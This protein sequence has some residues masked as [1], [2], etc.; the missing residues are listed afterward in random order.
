MSGMSKT[1][2]SHADP[3]F[4]SP[5]HEATDFKRLP[6]RSADGGMATPYP[7]DQTTNPPSALKL[8]GAVSHEMRNPLNGILGMSHLLGE[9]QLDG[10]QRNYLDAI[11]SSG[12]VLLTLVNDLLDLTALQSD[13]VPLSPTPTDVVQLVNQCLELAAPRAHGKGLSLGSVIDPVLSAA[14]S[15]IDAHEEAILLTLDGGRVRQVLT[16]LLS[17]AIKFTETGGVKLEVRVVVTGDTPKLVFDVRDTGHGIAEIDQALV[18]QTFGRTKSAVVAG[19]EGTGLGLPLSRGLAQAMGG[20]LRLMSSVTGKGTHMRLTLPLDATEVPLP[21]MDKPL[22]DQQVMLVLGPRL[23]S[24]PETDALRSTL[25]ALGATVHLVADNDAL[26][27]VPE[28]MDH[29]LIDASFDHAML[30]ARLCVPQAGIRPIILLKPD[31]RHMLA[32]LRDAG[33]CGYLIRPVRQSSLLAMLTHRFSS[34]AERPFLADPADQMSLTADDA[35]PAR[36]VLL[37]DDNQINAMLAKTALERAGHD[38]TVVGDGARAIATAA[39]CKKKGVAFD[40]ILLD[41]S[42]PVMDGFAAA[43]Q[44]RSAGFD[45]RLI[46]F[47]GNTDADLPNQIARAGFDAFA[48]KPLA[49]SA[50]QALIA[51]A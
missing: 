24:S 39:E 32:D 33:F 25:Q 37:A 12:E 48:Q 42:M 38:V 16:N 22:H 44:L 14:D 26:N 35:V 7:S 29:V 40:T 51:E 15:S 46:A 17:N 18:F 3:S 45:G 10:A 5:G 28:S 13:A 6:L 47:S 41:L 43:R 34:E 4:L 19:T 50:L 31:N 49:P 1:R 21:R 11:A 9:T 36:R 8:I 30:W 2:P 20:D 23:A 27:S